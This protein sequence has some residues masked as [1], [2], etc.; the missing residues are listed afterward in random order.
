MAPPRGRAQRATPTSASVIRRHT[1]TQPGSAAQRGGSSR[2][3]AAGLRTRSRGSARQRSGGGPAEAT[4]SAYVGRMRRASGPQGGPLGRGD[5]AYLRGRSSSGHLRPRRK[6]KMRASPERQRSLSRRICC[7]ACSRTSRGA[8]A[9]WRAVQASEGDSA[10][11]CFQGRKRLMR[12]LGGN[13][14]LV[15]FDG[16]AHRG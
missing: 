2:A 7:D 3:P 8:T 13:T 4:P 10:A 6:R 11:L 5:V 1:S 14:A 9:W 12:S 16:S 15:P